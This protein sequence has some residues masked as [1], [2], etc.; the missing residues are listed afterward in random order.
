M[1]VFFFRR[2]N[3]SFCDDLLNYGYKNLVFSVLVYF[4]LCLYIYIY[5]YIYI[6]LRD[7]FVK[8]VVL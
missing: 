1:G 3:G 8:K 5:I 7:I 6:S 4:S 2:T